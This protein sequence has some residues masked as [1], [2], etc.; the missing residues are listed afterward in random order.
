MG[1]EGALGRSSP[2]AL[3]DPITSGHDR[4]PASTKGPAAIR[5][6]KKP[7]TDGICRF[8]HRFIIP[9]LSPSSPAPITGSRRICDLKMSSRDPFCPLCAFLFAMATEAATL[10]KLT[11]ALT[12]AMY[13]LYA[14]SVSEMFFHPQD[15]CWFADD[16]Q[17]IVFYI[18]PLYSLGTK[19]RDWS[20]RYN[21]CF[22]FPSHDKKAEKGVHAREL[23]AQMDLDVVKSWVQYCEI[24]HTHP[25]CNPQG[26]LA[27]DGF[28]VI[29]CDA[30]ILAACPARSP[31]VTLSYVWGTQS[32]GEIDHG[33]E[34]PD[35]LP[36]LI[37][38]AM[39]VT[40]SL[41]YQYLWVDRY[42]IP[43]SNEA[44]RA[45]L[46]QNM[47][48]I[49]SESTL[50]IIASASTRPS[51]GLIGYG[52]PRTVLPHSLR[53]ENVHL[54]QLM[55]NLAN[56]VEQSRWNTRG[57][58]YQEGLLSNRRLLFT[59]S[60]CYFQCGELWCTEGL[61]VALSAVVK[62]NKPGHSKLSRIFPWVS[63]N[64]SSPMEI[65]EYDQRRQK[66]RY[67]LQR[68]R[69]YMRR[70]LTHDSDA[71][72]AFAGVLNYLET[73]SQ[74]FL[75][76]N[77]FGLPIWSYRSS[78][79]GHEDAR[80]SLSSGLTWS[81]PFSQERSDSARLLSFLGS[82]R[83]KGVPSWTWCGW[84]YAAEYSHPI[85]WMDMLH[86]PDDSDPDLSPEAEVAV[87]YE[88]GEVIPW[89]SPSEPRDLLAKAKTE[90]DAKLILVCGWVSRLIIPPSCWNDGPATCQCGPYRL[91]RN[92][93]R[94][95]STAAQLRGL[96]LRDQGYVLRIWF[97]A[98][99][100]FNNKKKDC[101]GIAMVLVPS[102]ESGVL[103]RLQALCEI[104]MEYFVQRPS[105]QHLSN[106]FEWDWTEFRLG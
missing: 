100:R 77:V 47:N 94:Y 96:S 6:L 76:G 16:A 101:R 13:A 18:S 62:L 48:R 10:A 43:Q 89:T 92:T 19:A 69:E 95:L 34:L 12:S 31:Y 25:D 53:I 75:L 86:Q 73:F 4:H 59:K 93:A 15:H 104:Q 40:L 72:N 51:D 54:T 64:T 58:T 1:V 23:T 57:W 88:G 80:S 45:E 21:S 82:E 98:P 91:G 38:H 50:T 26:P 105:I 20:L 71:Y 67:F 44:V 65:S 66:E 49:Y 22:M 63:R 85:E 103:E 24:A 74:G 46:I 102:A 41:G 99:L 27:L 3:A 78:L 52:T 29:D 68:V 17:S 90:G 11:G 83:R 30:R 79:P 87:E 61:S 35:R 8:C 55:T 9:W 32:A 33:G 14:T 84:K 42:C 7:Y 2:E 70:D 106:R 81:I 97:M 36:E 28:H 60:Q 37:E 5:A 39:Q 56:E